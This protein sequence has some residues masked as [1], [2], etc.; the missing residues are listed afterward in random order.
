MAKIKVRRINR[1]E[2]PGAAILRDA[3]AANLAA[4]P[5]NRG[6]LDLNMEIDPDLRNA[7]RRRS[8][9]ARTQTRA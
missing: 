6:I 2:L 3:V 9:S 1:E 5:S 7:A 4:F 8:A